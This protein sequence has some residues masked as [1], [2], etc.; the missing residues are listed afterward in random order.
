MRCHVLTDG[1]HSEAE[2]ASADVILLGETSAPIAPRPLTTH[3]V[4][5]HFGWQH[6]NTIPRA[7]AAKLNGDGRGLLGNQ[8]SKYGPR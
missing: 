1:G 5:S 4:V 7:A 6:G 2:M 3:L 8:K